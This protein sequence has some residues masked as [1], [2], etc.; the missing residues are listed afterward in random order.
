MKFSNLET[1][2]GYFFLWLRKTRYTC[3]N[4]NSNENEIYN[5]VRF[6][7]LLQKNYGYES[8][9]YSLI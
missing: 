1:Y 6:D 7:S 5:N 2:D 8:I 4:I 9:G 3:E